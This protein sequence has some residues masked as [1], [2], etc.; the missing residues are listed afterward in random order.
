MPIF[1]FEC[2]VSHFSIRDGVLGSTFDIALPKM[3]ISSLYQLRA[4][5]S[6]GSA[7]I[8]IWHT[9]NRSLY[10]LSLYS[11]KSIYCRKAEADENNAMSV[12]CLPAAMGKVALHS[13]HE[14]SKSSG[15]AIGD[16]T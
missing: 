16:M 4:D 5:S 1:G 8:E 10:S 14:Y 11:Y 3:H 13:L 9:V 15:T 7:M 2:V 6:H 12:I